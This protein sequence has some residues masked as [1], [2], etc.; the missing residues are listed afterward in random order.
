MVGLK[1]EMVPTTSLHWKEQHHWPGFLLTASKKSLL[2]A[3]GPRS[4]RAATGQE[5]IQQATESC[6][7]QYMVSRT[8][9]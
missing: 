2:E 1:A 3:P 6:L 7:Y 5:P 8:A 4:R 9:A